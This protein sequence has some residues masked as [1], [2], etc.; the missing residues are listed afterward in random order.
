MVDL[1]TNPISLQNNASNKS[2]QRGS[3][4]HTITM[5]YESSAAQPLLETSR[6]GNWP[7]IQSSPVALA[8][9]LSWANVSTN[10]H[11]PPQAGCWSLPFGS[12]VQLISQ[13]AAPAVISPG[14][15][16]WSWR[17]MGRIWCAQSQSRSAA[18]PLSRSAPP[19]PPL[20]PLHPW[21]LQS[22]GATSYQIVPR[23]CSILKLISRR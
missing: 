19:P 9:P 18:Q 5:S 10:V 17:K 6:R 12:Q 22:P 11:S 15:V 3:T 13:S 2:Q 23:L 4:S 8:V 16:V 14:P 21:R 1:W 7:Q 20:Y